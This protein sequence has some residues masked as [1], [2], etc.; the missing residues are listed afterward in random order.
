M[1]APNAGDAI[2]AAVYAVKHRMKV[3]EIADTWAPYLT[4]GEGLRLAAQTFTC[5]VS[6]LSCCAA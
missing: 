1:V 5:D 4:A 6:L 2:L 3:H